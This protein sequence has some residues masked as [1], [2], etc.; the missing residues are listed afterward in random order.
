MADH[1]KK[2]ATKDAYGNVTAKDQHGLDHK[3]RPRKSGRSWC[4][5]DSLKGVKPN[6]SVEIKVS[7]AMQSIIREVHKA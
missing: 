6:R 7:V 4:F 3:G 1:D 5:G 2:H